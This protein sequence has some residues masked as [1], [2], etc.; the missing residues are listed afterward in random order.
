MAVPLE[1][2]GQVSL[3][4]DDG[5]EILLQA[6]GS[7]IRVQI[8]SPWVWRGLLRQVGPRD[9]RERRLA[10][11][12]KGAAAADL[13]VQITVAGRLVAEL[14]G[15]SQG[16]VLARLLGLGPLKLHPLTLL[17]SLFKKSQ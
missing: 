11:L 6:N 4:A 17:R 3:L 2:D 9:V 14:A 13:E 12:Q 15:R 5:S 7:L 10:Q 8:P 16:S 1:V